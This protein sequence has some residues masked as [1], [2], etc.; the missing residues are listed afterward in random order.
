MWALPVVSLKKSRRI[1]RRCQ[2]LTLRHG[3]SGGGQ[4]CWGTAHVLGPYRGSAWR[5]LPVVEATG[6]RSDRAGAAPFV[7]RAAEC[8][9]LDAVLAE[10]GSAI[11]DVTG[12]A[13]I[14]KTRLLTRFSAKAR[15]QGLTVLS[16]QAT[17][18]EQDSPFRPFAD[19][20]ADLSPTLMGRF[21][22]L[23]ELPAEVRGVGETPSAGDR[24]GLC[25][26]TAGLL[27]QLG[28]DRLVV[29]LDD[30]HWADPAS[31][32]L[33]DHLVRHPVPSP[34]LLVVA[35]RDRQTPPKL[36]ASLARGLDTGA[37]HRIDLGPLS[38]CDCV[39]GLAAELP[40][41][42][43]KE[44]YAASGGNPRYFLALRQA[45]CDAPEP[46][47]LGALLL[48]ELAPLSPVERQ[49]LEAAA[50]LGD[51][52]TPTMIAGLTDSDTKA[53]VTA[54]RE[55]MRCDLLRPDFGGRPALR[56]PL[57]RDLVH[58]AID[59][60]LREDLHRRAAAE[61]AAA[62]ATIVD[63]AHHVE[64]SMTHWDPQAADVLVAAAEQSAATAPADSAR[65][66]GVVLRLLP[67]GPEHLT[68]RRQLT[69]LRAR[70][71]GVS[72][73]LSEGRDLLQ[74]VMDM[75]APDRYDD[76]R[77]TAATLRGLLERQLGRHREAEAMLR[78][79]LARSPEPSHALL[80][81]LELCSCVLSAARFPEVRADINEVLAS[82]RALGDGIGE[83]RA[84]AL[85]ALGEAYEG[86]IAMARV[87]AASAASLAETFTDTD[88]AELCETLCTL[89]WTEV[90]LEDYAAAESHLDRG[91]EIARRAGRACLVPQFLTAK[92]Y[93]H[94][95]TCRV[96]SALELAEEAEPLARA[97]GSGDLLAFH[98]G[99]P[100]PDPAPGRPDL[101]QRAG[102]RR[103]GRGRRGR[104]RQLVGDLGPVHARLRR[105]RRRGAAPSVGHPVARR[106]KRPVPA[107]TLDSPQ[108]PGGAQRRRPRRRRRGGRRAL[109]GARPQGGGAARPAEP[110][111][112]GAAQPRPHCHWPR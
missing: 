3:G 20:F 112:C 25:R 95:S 2:T 14:G 96:T 94:L 9:R 65:W 109:G 30:L 101:P 34:L 68:T 23:A 80:I 57:I 53:V 60:W 54:L 71:L 79:E 50:V 78:R 6:G 17:A 105:A 62:G 73:G 103:G 38:E 22:A 88:L 27:G 4:W 49:V 76:V 89:G 72:G 45:H 86:D 56:H 39:D 66:L 13:G 51:H 55:L 63:Q 40:Q 75:P 19:A 8:G 98:A 5:E 107:A 59:P 41:P 33:V 61:L 46:A 82:A 87:R 64:Q 69:V 16:G 100:V 15:A 47:C 106:R 35:R 83:M 85:I 21:P 37:V 11:V 24:F 81:G 97:L 10:G 108:Q 93:L 43:A 111:R 42:Q 12:E 28:P 99:G 91:L 104:R 1:G 77:V 58:D 32:E 31:L 18:Y 67:N 70:A 26:A 52:A 74:Q 84:L 48:D 29:V 7:G 110:A 36:A 44:L 90:F 92:A 102:R